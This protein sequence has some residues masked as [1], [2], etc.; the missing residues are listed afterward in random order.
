[1]P[2]ADFRHAAELIERSHHASRAWIT[3]GEVNLPAPERF[4][5]AHRHQSAAGV[6][7]SR[8]GC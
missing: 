6:P 4:L 2:P 8:A 1:V 5:S 3:E 7:L